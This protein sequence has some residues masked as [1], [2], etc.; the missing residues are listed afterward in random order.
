MT[1]IFTVILCSGSGRKIYLYSSKDHEGEKE[2]F[3]DVIDQSGYGVT[4]T[5]PLTVQITGMS[6][7]SQH[8]M[9]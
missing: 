2:L 3:I 8:H 6:S 7:D 5:F 9:M 4:A 1:P